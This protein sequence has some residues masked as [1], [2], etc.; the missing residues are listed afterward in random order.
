MKFTSCAATVYRI[1]TESPVSQGHQ[2]KKLVNPEQEKKLNGVLEQQRAGEFTAAEYE[3]MTDVA[4]RLRAPM[5]HAIRFKNIDGKLY[6]NSSVDG[7]DLLTISRDAEFAALE[8]A[9]Q[10]PQWTVEAYRRHIESEEVVAASALP[11]GA[12]MVIYSP[13]PDAVVSGAV[14]IG[15]YN[16]EKATTMVRVWENQDG[17][18]DCRYISLDGGNREALR[19]SVQSI[20]RKIPE[21]YDSEQILATFYTF[22]DRDEDLVDKLVDGYDMEMRRQT[23]TD[24]SYGRAGLNHKKALDIALENPNRLYDHMAEIARLKWS[25]EGEELRE[26]LEEARY[27]YAAAL[28]KTSRGESV[29]SNLAAGGEARAAGADFSGYCATTPGENTA[30]SNEEAY[31]AMFGK[32]VTGKC[33]C[34]GE[35]TTYDPCNPECGVCHS[36][37]GNDRSAEYFAKKKAELEKMS[38]EDYKKNRESANTSEKKSDAGKKILGLIKKFIWGDSAFSPVEKAVGYH[39]EIIAEGESARDL[40]NLAGW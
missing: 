39:G 12:Q 6:T 15:G 16:T 33:P 1:S 10:N 14:N 27:N 2:V 29:S 38:A 11:D 34:C 22:L 30:Q 37:A 26:K 21:D 5:D 8:V 17:H 4:E 40:Y 23:G 35:T 36:T 19:A 28:D 20:G 7:K 3:E 32:K 24:H 13:T 9:K 18:L 31:N 25:Y